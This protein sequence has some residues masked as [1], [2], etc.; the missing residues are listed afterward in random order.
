MPY[1]FDEFRDLARKLPDPISVTDPTAM[2]LCA[3]V[4]E[5]AYYH[6]PQFEIEARKRAQLI[7]CTAHAEIIKAQV[8]TNLL[9]YL[10]ELDFQKEA[11]V[12]VDRSVI[13]VAIAVRNI[14]FIGFRGTLFLYDWRINLDSSLYELSSRRNHMDGRSGGR[15]HRGFAEESIRIMKKIHAAIEERQ[16]D[17]N[18]IV[19]TGH[20]LGGAVASLSKL[21]RCQES[22][23]T[24][25]APRYCDVGFLDHQYYRDLPV[26]VQRPGDIVPLLPPRWMGYADHPVAVNTSGKPD[27]SARNSSSVPMF[28]WQAALFVGRRFQ[29]HDIGAYRRE[30][31]YTANAPGADDSLAPYGKLRA[32]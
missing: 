23:C 17:F 18:H 2:Y 29:Q 15:A 19:L 30:L 14:L 4:S 11:F 32:A 13:A 6:V 5:L 25:G 12:V 28:L 27:M 16:L 10:Q 31:G 22:V 7:P 24:L 3:L 8:T 21:H 20:S 1:A 26:Q 9:L